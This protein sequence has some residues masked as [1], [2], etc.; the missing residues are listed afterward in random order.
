MTQNSS[1]LDLV[2]YTGDT[3]KQH[4]IDINFFEASLS[5]NYCEVLSI[6]IM[7]AGFKTNLF[8]VNLFPPSHLKMPR[9]VVC[10]MEA[11]QG[12]VALTRH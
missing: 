2:Q 4:I 11:G 8:I 5:I 1:A 10:R 7:L 6:S 3:L 12:G 9:S